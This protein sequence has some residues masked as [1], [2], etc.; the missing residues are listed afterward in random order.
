MPHQNRLAV[1]NEPFSVR[2]ITRGGYTGRTAFYHL[3]RRRKGP[4]PMT[5]IVGGAPVVLDYQERFDFVLLRRSFDVSDK[6]GGGR[7]KVTGYSS[8][9]TCFTSTSRS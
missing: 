4:G 9:A 8:P 6:A 3:P 2:S 5:K 7:H 1:Q